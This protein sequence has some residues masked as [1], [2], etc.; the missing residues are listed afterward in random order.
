[1][2]IKVGDKFKSHSDL[3]GREEVWEVLKSLDNDN[4]SMRSS[5]D[6]RVREWSLPDKTS[7]T[8]IEPAPT[9][10]EDQISTVVISESSFK[11]HRLHVELYSPKGE[12]KMSALLDHVMR[13]VILSGLPTKFEFKSDGAKKLYQA[14]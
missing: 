2:E 9:A 12:L 5:Y 7:F 3:T 1:M 10:G 14:L 11:P 13:Y 6:G 4:Y 8:K